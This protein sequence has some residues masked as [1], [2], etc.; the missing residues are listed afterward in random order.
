MSN[1]SNQ[2]NIP[3]KLPVQSNMLHRSPE[4]MD[5]GDELT[6]EL[7]KFDDT[8]FTQSEIEEMARLLAELNEFNGLG[9]FV[10]ISDLV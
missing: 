3:A 10:D 1:M 8:D 7:D 9:Q 4:S 2:S 5:N 6:W